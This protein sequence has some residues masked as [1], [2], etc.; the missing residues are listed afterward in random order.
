MADM[1]ENAKVKALKQELGTHY[2][3]YEQLHKLKYYQ[4]AQARMPFELQIH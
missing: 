1:E 3:V 2:K 4:G